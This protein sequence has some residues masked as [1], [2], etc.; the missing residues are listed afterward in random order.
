VT[1]RPGSHVHR[2]G[3]ASG[4]S[5]YLPLS[6]LQRPPIGSCGR[7]KPAEDGPVAGAGRVPGRRGSDGSLKAGAGRTDGR[8]WAGDRRDD[9]YGQRLALRCSL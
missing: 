2:F 7:V 9:W 3:G 1:V 5:R 4:G 8:L 6:V